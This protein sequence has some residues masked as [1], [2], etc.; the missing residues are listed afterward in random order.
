MFNYVTFQLL[1]YIC[2]SDISY[3]VLLLQ[4]PPHP[5]IPGA[6]DLLRSIN[7]AFPGRSENFCLV[8]RLWS[9]CVRGA[10]AFVA[11]VVLSYVSSSRTD[12]YAQNKSITLSWSWP[13]IRFFISTI[14]NLRFWSAYW[15]DWGVVTSLT[16]KRKNRFKQWWIETWEKEPILSIRNINIGIDRNRMY[17]GTSYFPYKILNSYC[18]SN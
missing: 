12:L 4:N 7:W 15:M 9:G 6:A 3:D 8:L 14:E 18:Y 11:I 2:S 10:A 17:R 16:S 5:V 1:L 13:D